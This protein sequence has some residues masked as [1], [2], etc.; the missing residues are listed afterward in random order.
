MQDVENN[1]DELFRKA[2]SGYPLKT[3]KDDWDQIAPL[4]VNSPLVIVGP[5]KRKNVKKYGFLLLLSFVF[6]IIAVVATK[7]S[8]NKVATAGQ[9]KQIE[10]ANVS[11]VGKETIN[12]NTKAATRAQQKQN[13]PI[14]TL[15]TNNIA[16]QYGYLVKNK[17]GHR[18]K[19]IFITKTQVENTG[20][21]SVNRMTGDETVVNKKMLQ[22]ELNTEISSA[23][24]SI[25][26]P[27]D[28]AKCVT[29]KVTPGEIISALQVLLQHDTAGIERKLITNKNDAV[30]RQHSIYLGILLG[31]TFNQV[32]NQGLTKPGYDIGVLAGYQLNKKLS[33]ETGLL[34]EKKYYFSSGKY[35]DMAKAISNMPAGMKVLSLEGSC[36]VFEIPFKVKY[37]LAGKRDRHFY[38][39]AGISTYI[40]TSEYNKYK[41]VINGTQQNITGAYNNTSRYLAASFNL[42]AGYENKIG[43]SASIRLEPYLQIPLKGIGI[44]SLPVTT[45]GLHIGVTRFF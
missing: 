4:L 24:R 31:P 27:I 45:V 13:N 28:L 9:S 15:V 6:L 8:W 33:V 40:I 11:V 1:M 19:N 12:T 44:G 32:K 16:T 36:A 25:I 30:K 2:A 23:E 39:S 35:F 7:D 26:I 10:K 43:K 20:L 29:I 42:G 14:Q 34:F 18:Q 22:E 41:A 3:S 5:Q 38:S 17:M 21:G 37:N